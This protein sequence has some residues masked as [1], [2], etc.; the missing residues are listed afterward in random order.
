MIG[1]IE[2]RFSSLYIVLYSFIFRLVI[3][4]ERVFLEVSLVV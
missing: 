1:K 2:N 4:K 3:Y